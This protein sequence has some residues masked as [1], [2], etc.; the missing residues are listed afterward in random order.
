[1]THPDRVRALAVNAGIPLDGDL[2]CVCT[3]G[4]RSAAAALMLEAAAVGR[5]IRNHDGGMWAW[6]ADRSRPMQCRPSLGSKPS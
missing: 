1:M 6:S 5:T 3:G 4:V 2:V